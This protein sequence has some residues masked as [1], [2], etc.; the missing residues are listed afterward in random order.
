MMVPGVG[1]GL[2]ATQKIRKLL[3]LL[4]E[5][6]AKNSEFSLAGYTP[7]TRMPESPIRV[8]RQ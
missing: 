6:K 4:N 7:G 2:K 8:N 5:K 1:V 3:L